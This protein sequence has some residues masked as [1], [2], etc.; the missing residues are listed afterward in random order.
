MNMLHCKLPQKG[1]GSNVTLSKCYGGFQHL[2]IVMNITMVNA[3]NYVYHGY[4]LWNTLN[5]VHYVDNSYNNH[6]GN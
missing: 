5:Y 4:P 6:N 3:F 1:T 2:D